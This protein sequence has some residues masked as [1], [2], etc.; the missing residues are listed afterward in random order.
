M[1]PH[2]TCNDLTIRYAQLNDLPDIIAMLGKEEVCRGMFFGP[3][4]EQETRDYFEQ[5]FSEVEAA[6]AKDELPEKHFFT[7]LNEGGEFVG[8]CALLPADFAPGRFLIGYQLDQPHWR[9]GYGTLVCEF[10]I[11]YAFGKLGAVRLSGDCM[12]NNVGSKRV[13][14]RCNFS[15]EGVR[16]R[17]WCKNGEELDQLNFGLLAENVDAELLTKWSAK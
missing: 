6:L 12:S 2:F 7:V 16:L 15:P 10:L 1:N 17:Y 9:R 8:Q 3:N 5:P 11:G 13:M 14:E 4:T